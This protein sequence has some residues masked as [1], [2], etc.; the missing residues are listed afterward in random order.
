MTSF[1]FWYPTAAVV[2]YQ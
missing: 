2:G 1:S